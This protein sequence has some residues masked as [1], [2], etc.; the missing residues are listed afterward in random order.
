VAVLDRDLVDRGLL[1]LGTALTFFGRLSAR[2][3]SGFVRAYALA[4]FVGVGV[5][6]ILVAWMGVRA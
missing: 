2:L 1:G 6:V 4:M 5:L 3:Q